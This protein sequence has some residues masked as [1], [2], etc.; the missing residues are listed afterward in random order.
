MVAG[1]DPKE[2]S[3]A[4]IAHAKLFKLPCKEH[5]LV[6][7]TRAS[8]LSRPSE[9]KPS[10]YAIKYRTYRLSGRKQVKGHVN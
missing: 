3:R 2:H 4:V 9:H 6:E 1:T 5:L 7:L 10:D 8:M